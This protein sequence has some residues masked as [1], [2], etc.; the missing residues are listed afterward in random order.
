MRR[1]LKY[2]DYYHEIILNEVSDIYNIDKSR[3]FLGSRQKNIIRAKRLFIYTL[4]EVFRLTLKD[5]SEVTNL[6]HASIIHHSRQ[7]EFE[8]NNYKKDNKNFERVENRIIE[9]EID[10]E[11]EGLEKQLTK[12]NESLTKLYKINKLKHE[13]EKRENLL[14]E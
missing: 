11:I 3:I 8:Y 1:R 2:S 13:R 6:H 12:I 10:E 7:F 9:V 5:I 4:R 14:T